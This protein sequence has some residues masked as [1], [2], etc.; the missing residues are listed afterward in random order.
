MLIRRAVL[1]R[2]LTPHEL[3]ALD[4][5]EGETEAERGVR[6][7]TALD[8]PTGA[9]D[10]PVRR[11]LSRAPPCR[12]SSGAQIDV[13]LGSQSSPSPALSVSWSRSGLRQSVQRSPSALAPGLSH[14]SSRG[15]SAAAAPP[16][17]GL[18]RGASQPGAAACSR[19]RSAGARD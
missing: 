2:C 6:S 8:P 13:F 7:L 12:S 11:S 10:Q 19:S 18:S 17:R 4:R 15:L 14:L 1:P 16:P 9:D 5:E 3:R